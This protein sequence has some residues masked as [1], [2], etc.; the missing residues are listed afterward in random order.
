MIS[1]SRKVVM[2]DSCVG[3]DLSGTLKASIVPESVMLE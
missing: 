3:D 1:P 2:L